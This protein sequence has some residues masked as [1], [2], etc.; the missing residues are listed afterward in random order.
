M[1]KLFIGLLII[2]AGAGVFFFLR[3]K[4]SGTST[5]L[6]KELLVGKWKLD[7]PDVKTRDKQRPVYG[8]DLSL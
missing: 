8:F 3:N 5:G 2:A 6:Q 4:K 1:N 7:S